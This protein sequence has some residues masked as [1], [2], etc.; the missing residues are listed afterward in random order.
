[1]AVG[2]NKKK[3][4]KGTKKKIADAFA[5][6]EWYDVQAPSIFDQR[7]IGKTVVNKTVG[8]KYASE[9]L[10]GRVF[11][12]SLGDLNNNM[13]DQNYKVFELVVED[14]QGNKCLTNFYGMTFTTDK[15]KSLVRKWQTL[16]ESFVDIKTTDGYSVRL[17]CIGFT[18]KRVNQVRKTSYAQ[19]SQIRKIRKKMVE[20]MTRD[21]S[22]CDLKQ[23]FHKLV[24]EA[25]PGSISN[26]IERECQGIY[27]LQ[28]VFIRKAKILKKTKNRCI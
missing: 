9:G 26:Q 24:H 8:T 6:K 2:K 16:I 10:K 19:S 11:R 12:V 3:P 28:N 14:V 23:L 21:S 4:R 20:I 5:K 7:N 18:K 1:M 13:E 15:L 27:P 22:N 17:F 25:V